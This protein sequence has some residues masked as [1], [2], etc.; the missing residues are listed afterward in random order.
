MWGR[1]EKGTN[2]QPQPLAPS[3]AN[4][5]V[6]RA[7]A[8]QRRHNLA[9]ACICLHEHTSKRASGSGSALPQPS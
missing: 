1:G 8:L 2:L 4:V 7:E 9:R 5:G 6:L 3:N